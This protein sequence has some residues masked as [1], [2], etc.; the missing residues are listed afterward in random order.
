MTHRTARPRLAALAFATLAL[1][2][3]RPAAA[4]EPY[5]AT[6]FPYALVGIA[7]PINA[8]FAV[9][10]DFGSIAHHAYSGTTSTPA[11]IWSSR[12]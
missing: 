7:Q 1:A 6:G 4:V 12:F 3:A 8:M 11:F 5:A 9:R 2:A 10:A